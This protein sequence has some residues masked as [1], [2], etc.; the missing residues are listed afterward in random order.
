MSLGS[1]DDTSW[2]RKRKMQ[3]HKDAQARLQEVSL[4]RRVGQPWPQDRRRELLSRSLMGGR[5]VR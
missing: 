2:T 5:I 3:L 1:L 4:D